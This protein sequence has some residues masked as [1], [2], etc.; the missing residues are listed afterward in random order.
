VLFD[1]IWPEQVMTVKQH[2]SSSLAFQW[3][4][5]RNVVQTQSIYTIDG[6]MA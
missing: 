6:G 3:A 4:A 2:G 1:V 5:C